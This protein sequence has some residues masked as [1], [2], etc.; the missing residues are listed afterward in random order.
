MRHTYVLAALAA[1]V[2]AGAGCEKASASDE[3]FKTVLLD[4]GSQPRFPLRYAIPVGTKQSLDMIMDIDMNIPGLV[5]EMTMPRMVMVTDLEVTKVD[6]DGAMHMDMVFTDIRIED[7][8]GTMAGVADA[9]KTEI[10]SMKGMKM[11]QVLAPN[12]RVKDMTVD[13]SNLPPQM[14]EQ[15]KQA[16][17]AVDQMTAIL[18]DQ[19][20]GVGAR[21]RVEQTVLQQG[22]RMNMNATYEV[23]EISEGHAKVKTQIEMAA[24]SQTVEQN[25]IRAKLDKMTGVGDSMTSLDLAKLVERVA[26]NIDMDMAMSAQ[27]QSITM[28]MKMGIEIVPSGQAP[29]PPGQITGT[30]Q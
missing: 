14:R 4:E 22:I 13:T 10:D 6:P 12:G 23:V 3:K 29:S 8:P 5:G 2:V 20:V 19:P 26:A 21:W 7:R 28:T 11:T 9:M 17:Q 16:E 1:L 18:P 30:P 25:G 27:G 15:M 24:P